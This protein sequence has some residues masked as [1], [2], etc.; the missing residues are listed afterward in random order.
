V[1]QV[2]IVDDS[3]V[4]R[5]SFAQILSSDP[6]IKIMGKF[7][8]GS[9]AIEFI[10]QR[11]KLDQSLPHV[12][13]MDI[14]MPHMDGFE[15]TREIMGT[16]PIPIII[17]SSTLDRDTAEKTFLAMSVG[18]VAVVQKPPSPIHPEY[19][20]KQSELIRL[21]IA[22]SSVPV[23]RRWIRSSSL[24]APSTT[25]PRHSAKN[26]AAD[27]KDTI[28]GNSRRD[29]RIVAIG[30]STGGPSVI[31][32]ILAGLPN[33]FPVPILIVQHISSGFVTAM[34]EW[35]SN[36]TLY[37][38]SVAEN[39]EYP[40]S[41]H[42]YLA[43]DDRHMVVSQEGQIALV[44]ELS[45][46]GQKPSVGKLFSSIAQHYGKTA[47]GILLTGM[48]QDGSAELKAMRDSGSLTIAQDKESSVVYGMPGMAEK[49]DAADYF[50]PPGEIV[51]LL[52]S[53]CI[54]SD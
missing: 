16:T 44:D 52:R 24:T 36:I 42:A 40:L 25:T 15:T 47:I 18:A 49:L 33:P 38:V 28:Y 19:K 14:L 41:G 34:A 45:I 10:Q 35:M 51:R 17:T 23:I 53:I 54:R 39:G 5:E 4:S 3:A 11:K 8:Q 29:I 9:A 27:N 12:I 30:A 13:I 37:P 1:I 7:P 22:M 31:Q 43:P 21:V 20:K 6:S 2:L 50:L 26:I 46:N 32:A 48:G